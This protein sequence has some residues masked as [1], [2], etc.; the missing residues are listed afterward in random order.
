M[1][2]TQRLVQP[3]RDVTLSW[4]TPERII[5]LSISDGDAD[6]HLRFDVQAERPRTPHVVVALYQ[7]RLREVAR[8]IEEAP[9]ASGERGLAVTRLRD[10][11]RSRYAVLAKYVEMVASA[12][13]QA[14][15]CGD[16]LERLA[17]HAVMLVA[18]E[19]LFTD[20]DDWR[21]ALVIVDDADVRFDDPLSFGWQV[22]WAGLGI[23]GPFDPD[24]RVVR[25]VEGPF[26]Y[27]IH[28][29]FRAPHELHAIR[30]GWPV[31]E[32]VTGDPVDTLGDPE[33]VWKRG[34]DPTWLADVDPGWMMGLG[35]CVATRRDSFV[36]LRGMG[37]PGI[38]RI[39][40]L[41][42]CA[43]S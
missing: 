38:E 31:G 40:T 42:L 15:L 33:A 30:D 36:I 20:D 16:S 4:T 8:L 35:A 25:L 37:S 24:R 6:A 14:S 7:A 13:P 26:A 34:I 5:V 21:D 19:R 11:L 41:L 17:N 2:E 23:S 1:Y 12:T 32:V 18:H 9:A 28:R 10:Q 22:S 39:A 3:A 27:G 29:V 43:R